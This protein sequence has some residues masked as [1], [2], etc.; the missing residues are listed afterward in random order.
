MGLGTFLIIGIVCVIGFVILSAFGH[1]DHGTDGGDGLTSDILSLRNL[2]LFGTGF[3]AAGSLVTHLGFGPIWATAAGLLVG[4]VMVI[5]TV[6][7]FR[8]V[9]SQQ[10]NSVTSL[11]DLAGKAGFVTSRIPEGGLGEI[12]IRNV[13]GTQVHLCAQSQGGEIL[14]GTQ[15]EIVE[16]VGDRAIVKLTEST[17]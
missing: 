16:I 6:L 14:S 13:Q 7:F 17:Q 4:V 12:S 3:G 10:S 2:L 8:S 1:D 11:K 9:R 15:V 5:L